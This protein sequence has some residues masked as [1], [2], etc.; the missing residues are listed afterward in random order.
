MKGDENAK[1][2]LTKAMEELSLYWAAGDVIGKPGV[3]D[4]TTKEGARKLR[5]ISKMVTANVYEHWGTAKKSVIDK[6]VTQKKQGIEIGIK[7]YNFAQ[8][9]NVER[10]KNALTVQVKTGP[11][12][13]ETR[14]LVDLDRLISEEKDLMN[15]MELSTEARNIYK[16]LKTE[17]EDKSSLLRTRADAKA[18]I[19]EKGSKELQ[20]IANIRNSEEFYDLYIANGSPSMINGLR[21]S[22]VQTRL[23]NLNLTD[24]EALETS[25]AIFEDE[26]KEGVLYHVVNG[27]L[28]R[29]GTG[30]SQQT[31]TGFDGKPFFLNEIT[32][33]GHL[34]S[35][36]A[37]ANVKSILKNVGLDNKHLQY[38]EDIGRYFEYA[39]GVSLAR[40]DIVGGVRGISPNELIS[41][42]FNLARGMV[43]PT[44]VAGEMSARLLISKQQEIIGLAAQSKEASRIMVD[45]LSNP[46]AVTSNDIKTFSILLKEYLATEVSRLNMTI[47][48]YLPTNEL[49]AANIDAQ[50][51][52]SFDKI[53][54]DSTR[55]KQTLEKL[56]EEK[57]DETVQ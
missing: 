32:N 9:D 36:L 57:T 13:I 17:I 4:A 16:D 21:E 15:L 41:R 11:N 20:K 2:P 8:A 42:A 28:K 27:L 39:Q 43:S 54:N 23:S 45:M 26:F 18:N 38:L 37:D 33:A 25:R 53:F 29:A 19:K 10:V 48:S 49:V 31:L 24:P 51:G 22:Y 35:D 14:Q 3:F 7:D 1:R 50:E 40:Y 34:A 55:K 5:I 6:L 56:E 12:K 52:L 46:E 30:R 44:Y 47:P